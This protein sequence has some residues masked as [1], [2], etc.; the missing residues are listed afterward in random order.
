MGQVE[1]A[2]LR[3]SQSVAVRQQDHCPI[4]HGTFSCSPEQVEHFLRRE[5]RH[6]AVLAS[7]AMGLVNRN[8]DY[9]WSCHWVLPLIFQDLLRWRVVLR[10]SC[11]RESRVRFLLSCRARV[12]LI[13]ME[14]LRGLLPKANYEDDPAIRAPDF[15]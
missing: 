5:N 15:K 8:G 6:S 7:N 1:S 9:G 14:G 12:R 10:C 11:V 13:T 2:N 4:P 3:R